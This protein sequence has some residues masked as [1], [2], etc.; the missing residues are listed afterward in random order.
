MVQTLK[1]ALRIL[2]LKQVLE[3]TGKSRSSVYKDMA[4]KRFPACIHIG[5]R[6]VGWIE[7]EI[8]SHNQK[9]IDQSRNVNGGA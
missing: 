1:R 9:L 4:E 2:R 3:R 6:S 7:A 5:P 8:D